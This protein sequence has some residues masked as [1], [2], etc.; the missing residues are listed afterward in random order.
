MEPRSAL[1]IVSL[2]L[3]L[4][5]CCEGVPDGIWNAG[6]FPSYQDTWRCQSPI[7][8]A[9][10]AFDRNG[11]V[12]ITEAGGGGSGVHNWESECSGLVL[13]GPFYDE[14][15]LSSFD[16]SIA[17]GRLSFHMSR[18]DV[19]IDGQATC[20]LETVDPASHVCP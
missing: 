18:S 6:S 15:V 20:T 2:A 8:E 14:A 11:N 7:G 5:A 4:S 19:D 10:F 16:G 1:A 9:C 13:Y 12:T 17:E 3:G